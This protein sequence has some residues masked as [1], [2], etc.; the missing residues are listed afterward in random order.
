MAAVVASGLFPASAMPQSRG[1]SSAPAQRP[2]RPLQ[3]ALRQFT[4]EARVR[5]AY[6]AELV[7]GY[8][9]HC[10]LRADAPKAT[11]RCLLRGTRLD[12]LQT[13]GST[14]IIKRSVQLP[15]PGTVV[16]VVY[17][18][19]PD[20][21]DTERPGLASAHVWRG[22]PH[23]AVE[24]EATSPRAEETGLTV[25]D[26][27][28]RFVLD[29]LRAGTHRVTVSH[30]GYRAQTVTV[31]VPAGDTARV[32]LSLEP[33]FVSFAPVVVDEAAHRA[34][35]QDPSTLRP[36]RLRRARAGGAPDVIR[37]A[38]ALLGVATEAPFVDLHVQGGARRDHE[39]RLDGVPIRNPATT[40][41]LQGAFSPLAVESLTAHK[42][43]FG[44]R[45]G[46]ALSGFIDLEHDL[47]H[48]GTRHAAVQ[49]SPASASGRAEADIGT[50]AT[51][52]QVMGAGRVGLWSLYSGSRLSGVVR[53]WSVLDPVLGAAQLAVDSS[54]TGETFEKTRTRPRNRFY[55]VHAAARAELSP[56]QHLE[57]SGY[58]G[59]SVLGADLQVGPISLSSDTTPTPTPEP[60]EVPTSDRYTWTNTAGQ[61]RFT[62]QPAAHTMASAQAYVSHYRSSSTYETG[63]LQGVEENGTVPQELAR[64]S[65]A[66][67]S[68][69]ASSVRD[70]GMEGELA[71]D[72]PSS[73]SITLTGSVT[74]LAARFRFRNAFIERFQHRAQAVRTAVAGE[75]EVALGPQVTLTGGVRLTALPRRGAVYAEP[76]G[77]LRYQ[78]P[79]V[80]DPSFAARLSGGLYRQF[81]TEVSVVRDATTAVVPTAQAWIPVPRP[82]A[83]PRAYHVA[84]DT[85]WALGGA[86]SLAAEAYAKHQPHLLAV[87]YPALRASPATDALGPSEGLASSS[88]SAYGGGVQVAYRGAVGTGTLRYDYSY[89]ERTFPGRFGGRP[90]PVPW[91]A[92]HRLTLS[93][94]FPITSGF[95]LDVRG[96][97]V[98]GRAWGYRRAYYAY[99]LPIAEGQSPLPR[100]DHPSNHRLPPRYRLDLGLTAHR[101]LGPVTVGGRV[102]V[103]NVLG[104]RNVA[105]WGLRTTEPDGGRAVHPRTLPGRQATL[106]LQLRY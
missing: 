18:T 24:G 40:G 4:T 46:S 105:D 91:N 33:A 34:G 90:V 97:G 30:V 60:I 44:V 54:L 66:Q 7:E 25:T 96:R 57:V 47:D 86:W 58:R 1:A 71:L 62:A 39:V 14:Y 88:G 56:T 10:P 45:Q 32:A 22:E 77:A 81:T 89:A 93:G 9:T 21:V 31:R 85:R 41:R 61:V 49:V 68:D 55:D 94:Q 83:P 84:A 63:E 67:A 17:G 102:G 65:E 80:G 5:L 37:A 92:P 36:G 6:R 64:W 50:T 106:S 2:A 59:R 73:P 75:G 53:T 28:G 100:L 78:Q 69:A 11:L 13:S 26:S 12:F 43:G 51:P 8:T 104:R 87:D 82:H 99:L 35:W 42:A 48:P 23:D 16:G 98:W 38:D 19:R 70:M 76:R 29:G 95:A 79:A 103:D 101:R 27:T 72:A 15:A 20:S 3:D 74:S 52:I